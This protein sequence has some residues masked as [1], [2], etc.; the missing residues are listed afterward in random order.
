MQLPDVIDRVRPS[1][2]QIRKVA[3]SQPSSGQTIGTGFIVVDVEHIITAL[4]VVEAVDS[5]A[6]EALHIA[7]AGPNID[8]PFMKMRAAFSQREGKVIGINRD[9]DLAL[10]Y[11]TPLLTGLSMD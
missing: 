4:H 2:V 11:A 9:Q 8:T 6:G 10:V 5:T 7:F 1:V 3:V